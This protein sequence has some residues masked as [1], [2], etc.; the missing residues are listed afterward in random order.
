MKLQHSSFP[1][2]CTCLSLSCTP[3][4]FSPY[5]QD[6]TTSLIY[7]LDSPEEK[8]KL[9]ELDEAGAGLD[10]YQ[11]ASEFWRLAALRARKYNIERTLE[12]LQR[13]LAWRK[14]FGIDQCMEDPK[15][16]EL[17]K[18]NVLIA[19]GNKDNEGRYI[20]TVKLV[21]TDPAKFEPSYAVRTIHAAVESVLRRYPEAQARGIAMINDMTGASFSN[22]DSR[23]PKAMM[24]V[25]SKKKKK[26]W[27]HGVRDGG[28]KKKTGVEA[29]EKRGRQSQANF[30]F[31]A[32]SLTGL[33]QNHPHE[34]RRHLPVQSTLFSPHAA[35][36]CPAVSPADS[37]L[38]GRDGFALRDNNN[39]LLPFLL[40]LPRR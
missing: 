38:N 27:R 12:V 9:K 14:E 4:F 32:A 16:L 35:A 13:Y 26:R 40:C 34:I 10:F 29:E 19:A 30:N 7:Q 22:L 3:L 20:I 39:A 28:K 1:F 33:L 25:S 2:F 31:A 8:A 5:L 36:S 23:V 37:Y 17:L 21:R 6:N 11:Q 15:Y 24:Q 18:R